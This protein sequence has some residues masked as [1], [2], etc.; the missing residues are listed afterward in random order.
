MTHFD[1]SFMWY[2]DSSSIREIEVRYRAVPPE[3]SGT[4]IVDDSLVGANH[5]EKGAIG[6]VDRAPKGYNGAAYRLLMI[7]K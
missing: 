4:Q 1:P 6:D 2:D 5:K 3:Y 7:C